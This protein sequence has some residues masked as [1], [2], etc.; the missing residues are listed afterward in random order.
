MRAARDY[1]NCIFGHWTILKRDNARAKQWY[2]RCDCGNVCSVNIDNLKAGRST[3]C[4]KC[5]GAETH[6]KMITHG[7]SKTNL[8]YVWLAMRNRCYRKSVH[9][10]ARYGGRGIKVCKEWKEHFESFKE[11]ALNHGYKRGLEID[12]I[13]NNG[14]YCPENCRWVTRTQNMNNTSKTKHFLYSGRQY[15]ITELANQF[16]LSRKLLRDRL[17]K[18]WPVEDAISYQ[19]KV[20]NN[21]NLRGAIK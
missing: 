11:W 10:Y 1:T 12:R 17:Y 18:G 3:K 21:Q 15:T 2:A 9:G 6:N 5:K 4:Q 14:D 19:A 13:D 20:G 7:E 16:N 8:Y